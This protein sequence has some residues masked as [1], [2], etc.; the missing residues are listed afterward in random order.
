[1]KADSGILWNSDVSDYKWSFMSESAYELMKKFVNEC[2]A[3]RV[4]EEVWMNV[5]HLSWYTSDLFSIA[6]IVGH[7]LDNR[8]D[9]FGIWEPFV[10]LCQMQVKEKSY[11]CP[12]SWS[13][14]EFS[15]VCAMP[16]QH[17]LVP[18]AHFPSG[19]LLPA[20]NFLLV[21]YNHLNILRY[22]FA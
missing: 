4:N 15:I 20:P 19:I 9:A 2:V 22:C 7:K 11:Y 21:P 3:L 6:I 10:Q 13:L 5:L 1:M 12:R 18:S 8:V 14:P 16:L 17:H